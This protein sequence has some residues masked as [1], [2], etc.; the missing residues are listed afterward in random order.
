M[1]NGC[2]REEITASLKE[3]AINLAHRNGAHAGSVEVVE[4]E[5]MPLQYVTNDAFRAVVKAVR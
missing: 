2:S 3:E 4:M 1:P 5:M